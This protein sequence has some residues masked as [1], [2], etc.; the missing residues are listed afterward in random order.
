MNN[1]I[2]DQMLSRYPL[3]T[4]DDLTNATHEVMQQITLAGLYRG[5]FFDRAGFFGGTCLRIFYGLQ[6]FSED[7]DFSLL[8]ADEKFSLE[9][10]FEPITTE[11][12]ALGKEVVINKKVK[13]AQTNIESAFLK[14]NTEIYD[15]QFSTERKIKIKIE[16]DIKPP[17]D[18]STEYKLL[19]LP[20]SFMTRCYSLPDL[21]AGKMHAFLF[22]NWQNRVKGRDWYDFE[23][24]VRNNVTLNFSHL[25][26][27]TEQINALNEKEFTLETFKKMLKER[28]EKT[29][30]E[31]VKNDVR[32]F[33]KVPQ[34]MEIWSTEYFLQLADMIKLKK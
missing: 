6:R 3:A 20:F 17:P 1:S 22:R 14:E 11:F 18:F 5:G 21:Y 4:K 15:L 25:Q 26:K 10:Y 19:L 32:P 30:I 27:R 7:M 33:L 31:A 13:T 34:E 8:Q 2:F 29:N 28:I 9:N 16:V 24:Y 23:W 12:K